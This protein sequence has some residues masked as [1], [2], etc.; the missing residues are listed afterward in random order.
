MPDGLTSRAVVTDGGRFKKVIDLSRE[1]TVGLPTGTIGTGR[2]RE[3]GTGTAF[4]VGGSRYYLYRCSMHDFILE[5]LD[6]ST[7]IVYPKDAGYI[8]L[9]M[10]VFPG[11][12]VGEAGAGSGSLT[13]I[14]SRAVGAGG[15]VFAYEKEERLLKVIRRNLARASAFDNVTVHHRDA[16]QGIEERD[17]DAF[18]VDM[19]HPLA[20]LE[21]VHRALA[22]GGFLGVFCPTANQVSLFMKRLEECSFLITEV[23]ETYLR[24]YK[25]NPERLRPMDRM[26]AHTGYLLFAVKLMPEAEPGAS[27]PEE[28]RFAPPA[29]APRTGRRMAGRPASS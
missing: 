26:V 29:Q 19:K 4:R 8:M 24:K 3:L 23:S 17:L 15:R 2:L 25:L 28:E 27:G 18:F 9:Q 22:P 16:E 11:K 20:V 21:Q 14:F 7:Q 10:D 5:G 12:L 13:T 1:A 6:R